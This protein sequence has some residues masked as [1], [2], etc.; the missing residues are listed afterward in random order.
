MT[1]L[2]QLKG[3]ALNW[4][5]RNMFITFSI[6]FSMKIDSIILYLAKFDLQN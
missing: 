3:L 6:N 1:H 5:K 2:V 4:Q